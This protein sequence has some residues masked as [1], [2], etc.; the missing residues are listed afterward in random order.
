MHIGQ[1]PTAFLDELPHDIL[2]SSDRPF[3][4]TDEA[5]PVVVESRLEELPAD[6]LGSFE[7][8]FLSIDEASP[9]VV[10]PFLPT[11]PDEILGS[12]ERPFLYT[13]E[14]LPVIVESYTPELPAD[15]LGSFDRP[16]L[17]VDEAIPVVVASWLEELPADILGSFDAPLK[18]IAAVVVGAVPQPSEPPLIPPVERPLGSFNRPVLY[19]S[20]GLDWLGVAGEPIVPEALVE[21][22]EASFAPQEGNPLTWTSVGVPKLFTAA[23]WSPADWYFESH[24][25]AAV[26]TV[27]SRAFNVTT[28]VPVAGSQLSTTSAT[29][30]RQRSGVVTLT[31]GEHVSQFALSPG[32]AGEQQGGELIGV[33]T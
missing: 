12:F 1:A 23:N 4:Y 33:P 13:D 32:V 15:V 5:I 7:R 11:L 20:T 21:L 22:V 24:M 26:G 19:T 31:D 10:E 27:N 14:A 3:L 16:F 25:R 28:G 18:F 2:G 9:V 17:Y 6:I 8:P 30:I 29:I